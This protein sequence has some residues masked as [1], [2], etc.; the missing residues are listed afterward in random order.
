MRIT[1]GVVI[2]L[3]LVRILRGVAILACAF[4]VFFSCMATS[5]LA[6]LITD[7]NTFV[8]VSFRYPN[9]GFFL[10]SFDLALKYL[11]IWSFAGPG[12]AAFLDSFIY[13]LTM[14]KTD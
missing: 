1:G 6:K 10:E 9:D 4:A 12:A 14:N 2:L 11:L 13:F 7:F 3:D 8:M 5:S